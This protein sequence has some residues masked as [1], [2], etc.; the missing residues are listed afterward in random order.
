MISQLLTIVSGVFICMTMGM[1]AC[2]LTIFSG[3]RA[4]K[5]VSLILNLLML[6]FPSGIHPAKR[7][8][9]IYIVDMLDFLL[10]GN[11]KNLP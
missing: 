3:V 9:Y 8:Y 11:K 10:I 6:K 5:I 4:K 1:E 7:K 2:V